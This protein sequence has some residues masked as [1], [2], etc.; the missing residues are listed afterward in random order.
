MGCDG[1]GLK[2]QCY[3]LQQ[4]YNQSHT[5]RC[6]HNTRLK[7]PAG[8]YRYHKYRGSCFPGWDHSCCAPNIPPHTSTGDFLC[9]SGQLTGNKRFGICNID[10]C[11]YSNYCN[12]YMEEICPDPTKLGQWFAGKQNC[13]SYVADARG[14]TMPLARTTAT[15]ILS[16]TMQNQFPN[17]YKKGDLLDPRFPSR[18]KIAQTYCPMF[19]GVCNSSLTNYCKTVTREDAVKNPDLLALCGCF[20]PDKQYPYSGFVSRP[21]ATTC[22][23]GTAVQRGDQAI[24][25]CDQT[26]CVI[27]NVDINMV[28]SEGN[29]SLNQLCGRA[30]NSVCLLKDINVN[31][32]NSRVGS[33]GVTVDQQCTRC[34]KWVG[35]PTGQVPDEVLLQHPGTQGPNGF[36]PG[37]GWA[38][39][40]CRG[41]PPGPPFGKDKKWLIIGA[42]VLLLLGLALIAFLLVVL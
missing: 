9:C 32:V 25:R 17:P 11:P 15:R 30:G 36:T 19:P 20:M 41:G 27:D 10:S 38:E 14:S 5:T 6:Q 1:P 2:S 13:G 16:E 24:D 12:Q 35:D 28:N 21:C 3:D 26:V 34:Y 42:I 7:C 22:N 4:Y 31:A 40:P 18:L 23:N 37:P 8:Q 39:T 33:G 29:V